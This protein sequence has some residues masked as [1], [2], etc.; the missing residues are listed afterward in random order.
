M[1][2]G[3]P[4]PVGQSQRGVAGGG[5]TT[6][7]S[8]TTAS[9]TPQKTATQNATNPAIQSIYRPS[10]SGYAWMPRPMSEVYVST[11]SLANIAAASN[12]NSSQWNYLEAKQDAIT[13]WSGLSPDIKAS[14][15]SLA[16]AIDYRKTGSGLW[17]E[18]VEYSALAQRRGE[19]ISPYQWLQ[20]QAATVKVKGGSG[21]GGGGGYG[22][23]TSRTDTR[24]D[25]QNA[26][27]PDVR[28]LMDAI[29]MEMLG[30]GVTQKEATRILA[31]VRNYENSNPSTSTVSTSGSTTGSKKN[32]SVATSTTSRSSGGATNAG[33]QD[34]IERIL[35]QNPE[36]GDYQKATTMMDWFDAALNDRL[37]ANG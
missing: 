4:S 19:T 10:E 33:R 27:A 3:S 12:Y 8:T 9:S 35:A 1:A 11:S 5:S 29:S 14:I 24:T 30:R 18:A 36:Y 28:D 25:Y 2:D 21:S 20:Q 13:E 32:S 15:S 22:G 7:A 23:V 37:Q 26:P 17:R 6:T 34:V 16:K 31:K